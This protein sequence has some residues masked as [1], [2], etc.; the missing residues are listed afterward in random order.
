MLRV[1]ILTSSKRAVKSFKP[2]QFRF[3]TFFLKKILKSK[4]QKPTRAIPTGRPRAVYFTD[5]PTRF[6]GH[7]APS[8]EEHNLNS[9][10]HSTSAY[11]PPPGGWACAAR[12]AGRGR[13]RC[14]AATT[15][16]SPS[17]TPAGYTSSCTGS[18]APWPCART[19]SRPASASPR[20]RW[21]ATGERTMEDP[22]ST[23][24]ID[25]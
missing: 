8:R 5:R 3:N 11:R 24:S 21:A 1:I 16:A 18:I 20:S 10:A 19:A 25:K 14:G 22:R 4:Q 6:R 7:F 23:V 17:A 15:T 9:T 2:S 12:I 13:R